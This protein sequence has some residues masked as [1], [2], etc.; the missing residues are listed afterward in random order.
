[1]LGQPCGARSVFKPLFV[2]HW[3]PFQHAYPRDQTSYY[4]TLVAKMLSCGNPENMG[5]IAD[6]CLQCGQG[7][8]LVSMRCQ[9]SLC[10]RCAKV[11]VAHWVSQISQV[12]HEGVISRP[13]I[14]TGP[15]MFRTTFYHHTAVVLRAL[16]GCGVQCLDD[17]DSE[18][19]GKALKGGS[20]TGLHTHGRNGQ[21]H[22]PR[23]LLATS[24]GY[25]EAGERCEHW[26]SLP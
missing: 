4:D 2:D 1:M 17:F 11:Y 25:D 10:V 13:R 22:P 6:R 15:A 16:M 20:S 21:Y 7:K 14:L 8:H 3:E 12:L 19:R 23:H 9:S 26:Q 24:G 5:D 18:V